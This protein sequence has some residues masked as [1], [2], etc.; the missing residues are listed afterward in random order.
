PNFAL[1]DGVGCESCHG[2]AQEWLGLHVT[3]ARKAM[4]PRQKQG[5]GLI[6]TPD[7]GTP[8]GARTTRHVGTSHA[9]GNPHPIAPGPPRVDLESA[10]FHAVYPK[11]W[12]TRVDK[13]RYPDFEA[14][15]WLVGQIVSARASHRLLASRARAAGLNGD[16]SAPWPEFSEYGCFACHQN[17]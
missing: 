15:G 16:G 6:P 14:R 7:P 5:Y 10:A 4:S 3:W 11:H 1:E 2:A 13:A 9:Q 8:V 12:D 17:L